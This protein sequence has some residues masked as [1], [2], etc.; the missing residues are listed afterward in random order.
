M[1]ERVRISADESLLG[2]DEERPR[3]DVGVRRRV[4][5]MIPIPL[6][7]AGPILRPAIWTSK[8][9]HFE[10]ASGREVVAH[11][12]LLRRGPPVDI[13]VVNVVADEVSNC[14]EDVVECEETLAVDALVALPGAEEALRGSQRTVPLLPL[15]TGVL[16]PCIWLSPYDLPD[17]YLK[18]R[19]RIAVTLLSP[20]P[21]RPEVVAI[22]VPTSVIKKFPTGP[23]EW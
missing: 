4:V 8:A 5:R 12:V 17:D 22:R 1:N 6:P 19:V 11:V 18:E 23:V 3:I 9:K 20:G 16:C 14:P 2:S 13:A 7:G 10:P 21:P 15:P